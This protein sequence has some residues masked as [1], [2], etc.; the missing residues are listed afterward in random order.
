MQILPI[1]AKVSML[2]EAPVVLTSWASSTECNSAQTTMPKTEVRS[3]EKHTRKNY[4]A[5]FKIDINILDITKISY[6]FVWNL[7]A[8]VIKSAPACFLHFPFLDPLGLS[9]SHWEPLSWCCLA[10]TC[11]AAVQPKTS[12][13]ENKG[14]EGKSCQNKATLNCNYCF[15]LVLQS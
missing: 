5:C 7:I 13:F 1:P 8:E 15:Q 4:W 6:I 9:L 10:S 3:K 12:P 14:G 2:L 11:F